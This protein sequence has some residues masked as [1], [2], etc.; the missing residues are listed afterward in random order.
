V[1][2][3]WIRRVMRR[4]GDRRPRVWITEAGASTCGGAGICVSQERQARWIAQA[5]RLARHTRAIRAI[6]VYSLTDDGRDGGDPVN[7][8]GLTD[9]GGRPKPAF[10]A[11]RRA[12]AGG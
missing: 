1:G 2:G 9:Y 5:V 4:S 3:R 6:I 11:F 10:G 8:Y 12:A 7:R